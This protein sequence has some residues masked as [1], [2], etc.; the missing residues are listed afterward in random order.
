MLRAQIIVGYESSSSDTNNFPR[1]DQVRRTLVGY[2]HIEPPK[3]FTLGTQY[4]IKATAVLQALSTNDGLPSVLNFSQSEVQAIL[5]GAPEFTG[6]SARRLADGR[7]AFLPDEA[8]VLALDALRSAAVDGLRRAR[9][10]NSAIRELTG[11]TPTKAD[12]SM[13][14]ADSALRIGELAAGRTKRDKSFDSRRSSVERALRSKLFDSLTLVRAGILEILSAAVLEIREDPGF[15]SPRPHCAALASLAMYHMVGA[16]G[17]RL[18]ER[19]TKKENSGEAYIR[20]PNA[21]IDGLTDTVRGLE[22]LAQIVLDGR[23]G[24]KPQVLP[25]DVS[26]TDTTFAGA[27]LLDPEKL[28]ELA[29]HRDTSGPITPTAALATQIGELRAHVRQLRERID[30]IE[31]ISEEL[32]S[33]PMPLIA[34]RGAALS[35]EVAMLHDA[36]FTMRTWEQRAKDLAETARREFGAADLD[37]LDAVQV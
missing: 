27:D 5:E 28:R 18:L 17:L 16:P 15:S 26:P 25:D 8:F 9:I 11:Q 35:D 2:I 6:Q 14:A 30:S 12:R 24:R 29:G 1:F 33:A 3:P 13:I 19:A 31:A 20:E 22:Q 21:V 4:A 36:A 32:D 23:S 10:A 7:Q 34:Q 37:A